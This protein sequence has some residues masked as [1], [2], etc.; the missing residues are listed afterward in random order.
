M[1]TEVS[2]TLSRAADILSAP[3]AW[4]QGNHYCRRGFDPENMIPDDERDD[5]S[6]ERSEEMKAPDMICFCLEGAIY[7]AA[8]NDAVANRAIARVTWLVA[9]LADSA[10]EWNDEQGRSAEEVV[11]ILREAAITRAPDE[12]A[13]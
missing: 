8:P 2:K 5:D 3:E 9:D 6:P 7:R 13:D 12:T 10:V 4:I 1:I 11:A